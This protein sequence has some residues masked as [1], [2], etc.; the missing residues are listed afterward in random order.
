MLERFSTSV[1]LRQPP[2]PLP[3]SR[4]RWCTPAA[5]HATTAK[6]AL[7]LTV[8]GAGTFTTLFA[9][10]PRPKCGM[11]GGRHHR[12]TRWLVCRRTHL[13]CAPCWAAAHEPAGC[14]PLILRSSPM[15]LASVPSI[16]CRGGIRQLDGESA[17]PAHG[18]GC[19]RRQGAASLPARQDG[20][21]VQGRGRQC[22]GAARKAMCKCMLVTANCWPPSSLMS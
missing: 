10:Q 14:G 19:S 21:H 18:D 4:N 2:T 17:A 3:S 11:P 5:F 13:Q 20:R 8:G 1:S 15:Q 7:S 9:G 16:P 6:P 22:G 12:S